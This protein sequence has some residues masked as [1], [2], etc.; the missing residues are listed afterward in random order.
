MPETQAQP[1]TQTQT[2]TQPPVHVV[3]QHS[4]GT[5]ALSLTLFIILAIFCVVYLNIRRKRGP[6]HVDEKAGD[7]GED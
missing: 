7:E 4:F 3:K 6:R 5:F 1:Q 2:Q